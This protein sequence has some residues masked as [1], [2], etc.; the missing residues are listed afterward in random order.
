MILMGV[1]K[2]EENNW[3]FLF[4][5]SH[6]KNQFFEADYDWVAESPGTLYIN[7]V[8]K[9]SPPNRDKPYFYDKF[10]VYS[11]ASSFVDRPASRDDKLSFTYW[12]GRR[13]LEF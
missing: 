11:E 13:Y 12:E 4:Q 8:E 5:N 2:D 7:R 6:E 1:R 9:W 3:L 10:A